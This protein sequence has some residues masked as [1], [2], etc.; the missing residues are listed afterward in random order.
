MNKTISIT[1]SGQLFHIEED[2]YQRLDEYLR[3]IRQHFASFEGHDEIVADIEARIAEHFQE[4]LTGKQVL[5]PA[6]VDELIKQMGTVHDFAEFSQEDKQEQQQEQPKKRKKLYRDADDQVLGGVAS[7]LAAYFGIDVTLMRLIFV[8]AAISGGWGIVVYL[9]LW[10][11]T[12]EANTPAEK[13]EMRGE[14]MTLSSIEQ[15][16]RSAMPKGDGSRKKKVIQAP[17]NAIA[18]LFEW[19][20]S[21]ISKIVPLIGKIVGFFMSLGASILLFMVTFGFI[22]M[23]VNADSQYVDFPLNS[24]VAPAVFYT[25]SIAALIAVFVP[26]MFILLLGS[27]LFKGKSVFSTTVV[28]SLIAL[29]LT[30]LMVGG[31]TAFSVA[32]EYREKWLAQ[33]ATRVQSDKHYEVAAFD[34]IHISNGYRLT[35]KQGETFTV[36][37]S[38]DSEEIDHLRVFVDNGVLRAERES[39]D[40]PWRFC[41]F[42][43]RNREVHLAVTM[44]QIT[45]IAIADGTYAAAE[46][47]EQQ[48]IIVDV[49]NGSRLEMTANIKTVQA[50]IS[51]A[52][53]LVFN[54]N[55][56]QVS[57][58]VN[59]GSRI[60]WFGDV[61][62]TTAEVS[63]ASRLVMEGTGHDLTAKVY[64]GSVLDARDFILDTAVIN[65]S[66]ASR[67]EVHAKTRLDARATNSS[68]IE[69][70]D[71][72]VVPTEEASSGS[73][74]ESLDAEYYE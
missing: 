14:P 32:P 43:F 26:L 54:G 30:S 64:N 59:N 71:T 7:G 41:L 60:E 2:A 73:S 5:S 66:S 48:N 11:V 72:G 9:I 23:M 70:A 45:S 49:R 27:S 53:R 1:I 15:K 68:R 35:I 56:E 21:V 8:I 4:R 46:G 39:Y 12:P 16:I 47:F 36:A 55:G 74:I 22:T 38:G 57:L 52:S 58:R 51:S 24:I 40:R 13:A 34:K 6:D 67:A 63:S 37:A 31:V 18:R 69:Y 42:C 28:G 29:W 20:A 44:P 33:E 50:E 10:L 61:S 3:S 19:I 17:L 65:A 62:G 25:V